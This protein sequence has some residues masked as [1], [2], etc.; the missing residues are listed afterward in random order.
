MVETSMQPRCRR[1][2]PPH[3]A[4]CASESVRLTPTRRGEVRRQRET[5]GLPGIGFV[6]MVRELPPRLSRRFHVMRGVV[7]GPHDL[8][9]LAE[10][11]PPHR[12]G[13]AVP[14][15]R[16]IINQLACGVS[17]SLQY[18]H[19]RFE[20]GRGLCVSQHLPPFQAVSNP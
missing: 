6:R 20:S 17:V 3:Q 8:I 16:R 15:D 18:R 14:A 1:T 10:A 11:D 5:F 12:L 4:A 7:A 9:Q 19:R 2:N 13:V